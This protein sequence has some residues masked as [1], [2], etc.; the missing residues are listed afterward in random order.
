MIPEL[1]QFALVL[2]LLLSGAQA[3]F[4]LW[5]AHRGNPR[6][7]AVVRPAVA[8]QFVLVSTAVAV[9]IQAFVNFD[10]SVLYVASNSNSALPTFYR[11]AAMWGAHE[12]SLL[13]WGWILALWTLAVAMFSRNL[14]PS[15]AS[16]VIGVLGVVS[17]CFLLFTLYTSNPFERLPLE[18]IPADGRDLNPV[19]QDRALAIHP[20]LL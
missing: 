11:V 12:G 3:Y 8:G 5:G 1:G 13:L 15:F 4:G 17:F 20:P 19:L 7:M 16:R 2:A 18:Q 10:F 14:P 9:L 6:Y